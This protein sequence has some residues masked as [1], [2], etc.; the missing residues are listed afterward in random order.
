VDLACDGRHVDSGTGTNVL[1]SPLKAI[2][3]LLEVLEDAP[4]RP[5][6]RSGEIVTTGTIT[7]AHPIRP[8]ETWS[9]TVRGAPLP[10]LTLAF[11]P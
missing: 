3:H 6:L 5:L 2:A 8:G 10:G 1:G 9:T 4:G 7:F 11:Q